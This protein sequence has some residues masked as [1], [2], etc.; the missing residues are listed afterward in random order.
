V[1]VTTTI[2]GDPEVAI[3]AYQVIVGDEA[4]GMELAVTAD[5]GAAS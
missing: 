3:V 4:S 5:A 1:P 2:F